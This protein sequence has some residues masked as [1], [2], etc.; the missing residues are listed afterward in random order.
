MK[1]IFSPNVFFI[2]VLA[3]IIML[4]SC[5]SCGKKDST[6]SGMDSSLIL[7]QKTDLLNAVDS[8]LSIMPKPSVVPNLIART[9]IEYNPNL[10]SN[11][12]S[13]EKVEGNSS[14]TAFCLG[15]L[16]ADIA[17]MASYEKGKEAKGYFIAGKK[18]ADRIGIAGAFDANMLERLEQ[19]LT[20]RE[21]LIDITD[22]YIKKSSEILRQGEQT[23]DAALISAGAVIEGLYLAA[24]LI[25]EYPSTGL[26]KEEQEK[27]LIPL[28]QTIF[29][30]EA[31]VHTLVY[32]LD[33]VEK[34]EETDKLLTLFR[35]LSEIYKTGNWNEKIAAAKGKFSPE[36]F[37]I[38]ELDAAI[39]KIRQAMVP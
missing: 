16:G 2:P 35:S 26:P 24:G 30:Q 10:L 31:S 27:I 25:R 5:S 6:A 13:A 15:V 14:V 29:E 4:Q 20:N 39:I 23:K 7:S 19:N 1:T 17:Y 8:L 33:K 32:L 11:L 3:G 36:I 21:A 38:A 18:M 22:G 34:D 9:G 37:E 28:Y 12:K